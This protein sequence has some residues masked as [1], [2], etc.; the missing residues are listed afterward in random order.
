MTRIDS[1]GIKYEEFDACTS[2][3]VECCISAL[4]VLLW[5]KWPGMERLEECPRLDGREIA[6]RDDEMTSYLKRSA[7]GL[8]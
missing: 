1:E 3:L 2:R 4:G 8:E 7:N 6:R 5:F